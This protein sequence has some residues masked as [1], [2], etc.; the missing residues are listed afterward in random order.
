MNAPA[1]KRVPRPTAI[2]AARTTSSGDANC[3]A[4]SSASHVPAPD[5]S[6]TA[7]AA[8]TIAP[9][10]PQAQEQLVGRRAG[11][12]QP[13]QRAQRAR[14]EGQRALG[15]PARERA[16]ERQRARAA[17]DEPPEQHHLQQVKV[18]R[19]VIGVD[20]DR[21]AQH[22]RR[23]EPG[24]EAGGEQDGAEEFDRHT[25]VRGAHRAHPAHRIFVGGE[26]QRMVPVRE[27]DHRGD[28]EHLR[29][30][31]AQQQVDERPRG[32]LEKAQRRRHGI[33]RPCDPIGARFVCAVRISV[34]RRPRNLLRSPG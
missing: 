26:Q 6:G 27:L 28:E 23:G 13:R 31:Q 14:G 24:G 22:R 32:A 18:E 16:V 21:E 1:A 5:G 9:D 34:H 25:D 11:R 7:A 30:P 19:E 2:N 29:E 10:R 8:A 15:E 33:H 4:D 17:H 12:R 20:D 3:R